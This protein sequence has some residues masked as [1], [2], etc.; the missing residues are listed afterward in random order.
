MKHSLARDTAITS[1]ERALRLIVGF[2]TTLL[3]ARTLGPIQYGEYAGAIALAALFIPLAGAGT[4][5]I[6]LREFVRGETPAATVLGTGIALRLLAGLAVLSLCAIAAL[7]WSPGHENSAPLLLC[8]GVTACVQSIW[9]VEQLLLSRL[10]IARAAV[11]RS[12]CL[13]SGLSLKLVALQSNSPFLG[14]GLAGI[15]EA[16]LCALLFIRGSKQIDA[17]VFPLHWSSPYFRKLLSQLSPLILSGVAVALY[18]RL[19]TLVLTHFHGAESAGIYAAAFSLSEAWYAI[20][21]AVMAAAAPRLAR[22]HAKDT[23]HF[24]Q[25]LARLIRAMSWAGLICVL[26]TWLVAHQL[27]TVVFGRAY[28]MSAPLLQLH[29]LSSWLVFISAAADPWYVNNNL[30]SYVL[31]KTMLTAALNLILS[32]S[33]I[34]TFGAAG[35]ALTTVVTY[36][37]SAIIGNAIWRQTRPLFWLQIR[38]ILRPFR[39]K[40]PSPL[41]V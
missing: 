34:P 28:S 39:S 12:V 3:I 10:Q 14:L 33:L 2:A 6:L 18:S 26:L 41:N 21:V 13:L 35:A 17:Q 24:E 38:N 23:A 19:T 16:G 15:F 25:Q 32:L 22:S 40:P 11:A 36:C 30:Q 1:T 5:G 9:V 8:L 31:R 20:P 7:L 29:V 37:F 27:V 4:D